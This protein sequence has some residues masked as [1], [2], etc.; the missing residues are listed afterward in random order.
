MKQKDVI[1]TAQMIDEI[2]EHSTNQYDALFSLYRIVYPE[3][4]NIAKIESW[5]SISESTW[6][7]ICKKFII[8]DDKYHPNVLNGGL[9]MNNGFSIKK[10][11]D[12]IVDKSNTAIL[13][14][15]EKNPITKVYISV[16]SWREEDGSKSVSIRIQFIRKFHVDNQNFHYRHFKPS[17]WRL[18]EKSVQLSPF[19]NESPTYLLTVSDVSND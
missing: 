18:I 10:M 12:W 19:D 9:W 1:L 13:L 17:I 2:F 14:K 3:W 7:Y 16:T 4:D 5:P 15:G 6:D 11:P 8:L